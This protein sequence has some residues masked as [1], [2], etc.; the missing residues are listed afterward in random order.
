MTT[1]MLIVVEY[2][3]PVVSSLCERAVVI[4]FGEVL[5]EVST[6]VGFQASVAD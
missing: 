4:T 6:A 1:V 3:I 5:T 2:S